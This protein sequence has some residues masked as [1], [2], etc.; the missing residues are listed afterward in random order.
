ML[1]AEDSTV[2][3]QENHC[4]RPA[5]PQCPKTDGVAV[6]VGK[7]DAGQP[8]AERVSHPGILSD[9]A[10]GVK[11][12]QWH[13]LKTARASGILAATFM[14][15]FKATVGALSQVLGGI[16]AL[17]FLRAPFTSMGTALMVGSIIVGVVCVGAYTWSEPEDDPSEETNDSQ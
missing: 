3:A 4:S 17:V 6:N 9:G 12:G 2:V 7:R 16:A 14:K 15:T 13:R 8:A 10:D 5:C 11:R 1:T